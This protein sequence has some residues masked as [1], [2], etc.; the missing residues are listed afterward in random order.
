[1]TAEIV[2]LFAHGRAKGGHVKPGPCFPQPRPDRSASTNSSR[3]TGAGSLP[4]PTGSRRGADSRTIQAFASPRRP[5]ADAYHHDGRV[6][7]CVALHHHER[8]D[9]RG[10]PLGL[11]G[12]AIPFEAQIVALAD[13]YD[14]LISGSP[15]RAPIVAAEALMEIAVGAGKRFNSHYVA[16][17]IATIHDQPETNEPFLGSIDA[18]RAADLMAHRAFLSALLGEYD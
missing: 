18:A 5:I 17:L 12:E 7:R 9:G 8:W 11:R 15:L 3:R 2:E 6:L 16:L 10:Y 1:M 13:T 14:I 4:S